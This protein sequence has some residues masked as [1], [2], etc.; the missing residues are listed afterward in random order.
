MDILSVRGCFEAYQASLN[1]GTLL[2]IAGA[3]A[4][5]TASILVISLIDSDKLAASL[6]A[7]TALFADLMAS[8]AIFNKNRRFF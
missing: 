1:A 2:K 6:A 7:I 4:I 3:I 8:M 5:L